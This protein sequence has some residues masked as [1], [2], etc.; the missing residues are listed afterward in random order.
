[1][2]RVCKVTLSQECPDLE[3]L[4]I[5]DN[6]CM[7]V[8]CFKL[9]GSM[10]SLK[11]VVLGKK[12]FSGCTEVFLSGRRWNEWVMRPSLPGDFGVC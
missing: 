8:G 11:T 12:V 3:E 1:M 2:V 4:V 5:E 6:N 9:N 10:C 7:S